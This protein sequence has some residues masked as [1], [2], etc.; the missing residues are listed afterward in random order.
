MNINQWALIIGVVLP[1]LVGIITKANADAGLKATLLLAL[2][3]LN[4]V[5]VEFFASPHG[6][7]WGDALLNALAAFI[8]GVA[9]YYGFLKHTVNRPVV[10]ATARFGL[11]GSSGYTNEFR[12]DA[13]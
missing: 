1:V 3:L 4:G 9:A 12:R 6:F 8:T 10:D 11:G 13:A 5:L 7:S 2:E